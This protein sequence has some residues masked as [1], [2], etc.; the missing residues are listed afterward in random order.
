MKE[1]KAIESS[2]A[3]SCMADSPKL[4][5]SISKKRGRSSE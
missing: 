5:N 2:S 1:G 3:F 4:L